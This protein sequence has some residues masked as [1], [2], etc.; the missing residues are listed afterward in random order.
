MVTENV[1]TFMTSS[2]QT[3]LFADSQLP[4]SQCTV[5]GKATVQSKLES[6]RNGA[7]YSVILP[8]SFT[9]KNYQKAKCRWVSGTSYNYLCDL[10]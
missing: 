3:D 1:S 6:V 8:T 5:A 10:Y 7:I 2:D 4:K 9:Q